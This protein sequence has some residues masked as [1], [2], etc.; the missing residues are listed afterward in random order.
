VKPGR[1]LT[2][3]QGEVHAESGGKRKLVAIITAT[4]M[5]VEGRDEVRD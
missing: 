1:T 4:L 5:A 3:T 2:V